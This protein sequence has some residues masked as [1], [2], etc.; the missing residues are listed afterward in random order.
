MFDEKLLQGR[1]Y[2]TIFVVLIVFAIV[3]TTVSGTKGMS[4]ME[5][6]DRDKYATDAN[7]ITQFASI[8]ARRNFYR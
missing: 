3:T 6:F 7:E 1:L 2:L 4:E 8:R 5:Q